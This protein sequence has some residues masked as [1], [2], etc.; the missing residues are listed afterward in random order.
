MTEPIVV[1]VARE[2]YLPI[3]RA[4]AL[5]EE[6]RKTVTEAEKNLRTQ[7]DALFDTVAPGRVKEYNGRSRQTTVD[8]PSLNPGLYVG[9]LTEDG[10]FMVFRL[11]HD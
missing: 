3:V 9:E 1:P 2:L 8:R 4:R 10:R 11:A 6:A 7:Q 5:L